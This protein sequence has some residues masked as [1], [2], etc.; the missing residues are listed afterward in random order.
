MHVDALLRAKNVRVDLI[1]D[2]DDAPVPERVIPGI[3]MESFHF[4]LIGLLDA[5]LLVELL[6]R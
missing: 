3:S 4:L 2:A 6:R 5:L 1:D